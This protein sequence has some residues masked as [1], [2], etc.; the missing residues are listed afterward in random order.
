MKN[1][2]N[3]RVDGH[4]PNLETAYLHTLYPM[5][6][7]SLRSISIDVNQASA[8][9]YTHTPMWISHCSFAML[10]S[11]YILKKNSSRVAAM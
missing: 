2:M 10:L 8:G 7:R 3:S 9:S 6:I 11:R 4:W 5:C 1:Q